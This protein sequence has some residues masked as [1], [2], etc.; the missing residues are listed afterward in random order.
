[1]NLPIGFFASEPLDGFSIWSRKI[2]NSA[3]WLCATGEK[4]SILCPSV[5]LSD[6]LAWVIQG[7]LL[8]VD[9]PL[10]PFS[11][12]LRLFCKPENASIWLLLFG[13]PDDTP[14]EFH[15]SLS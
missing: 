7:S 5:G 11:P 6:V 10:F 14:A 12:E 15:G 1:M 4:G 13:L 3:N 9:A 2:S 8:A